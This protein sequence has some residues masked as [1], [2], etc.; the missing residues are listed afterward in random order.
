MVW[1]SLQAAYQLE[2]E[3]IHARVINI[4]AIKP[5]D[6]NIIIKAARE[7][8]AIVTAEEHQMM[9]GFGSAVAEVIVRNYPVPMDFIGMNDTFG[10]SG[11]PSELMNKYG[12]TSKEIITKAKNLLNSYR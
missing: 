4:Y 10:E 7:T 9:G 3:G 2:N 6:E 11:K 8:G 1:E 5:I 12:L